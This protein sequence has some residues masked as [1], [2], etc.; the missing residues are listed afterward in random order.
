MNLGLCQNDSPCTLILLLSYNQH[1][2]KI[3][4]LDLPFLHLLMR[5][6]D[7]WSGR[8]IATLFLPAS[9]PWLP[10][11]S[12][13][14]VKT[15]HFTSQKFLKIWLGDLLCHI[16]YYLAQPICLTW[17][18]LKGFEVSWV[19]TVTIHTPQMGWAVA[20]GKALLCFSKIELKSANFPFWNFR[21]PSFDN[22]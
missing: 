11:I 17:T 16:L 6:D 13:W 5:P 14:Q 7:R 21:Y 19:S 15:A 10:L 3:Y 22:V 9:L 20:V 4:L 1:R 12:R 8:I 18:I 2:P